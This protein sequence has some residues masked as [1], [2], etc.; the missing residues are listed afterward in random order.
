MADAAS[1]AADA[2]ATTTEECR[3]AE[4][5]GQEVRLRLSLSLRGCVVGALWTP[6]CAPC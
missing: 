3:T 6:T 2:S 5:S 1:G 4:S